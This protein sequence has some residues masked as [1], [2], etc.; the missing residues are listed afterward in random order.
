MN[1]FIEIDSFLDQPFTQT[2][3][4]D[5]NWGAFVETTKPST[6]V[7]TTAPLANTKSMPNNNFAH[8]PPEPVNFSC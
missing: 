3:S 2:S 5:V 1:E 4:N 7:L 6:N 8:P